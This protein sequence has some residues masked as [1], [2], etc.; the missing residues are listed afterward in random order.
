MKPRLKILFVEDEFPYA[1]LL[2]NRFAHETDPS[3]E[4]THVSSLQAAVEHSAGKN[5]DVVL[6]DLCLPD[7]G[8]LDTL[9]ALHTHAPATPIVVL[10]ALGDGSLGIEAVKK[11]AQDYL[12]KG[13]FEGKDLP[14]FLKYAIARHEKQTELCNLS[15]VD[16]LTGLKNRRGLSVLAEQQLKLAHRSGAELLF[17]YIDLDGLKHVN[18]TYGHSEGDRALQAVAQ[19]LN[20]TFRETDVV[21]RVGG[22][23]FTVL[24]ID[25]ATAHTQ[26]LLTRLEKVLKEHNRKMAFPYDLSLSVGVSSFNLNQPCSLDELMDRADRAMY[27]QKRR[28]KALRQ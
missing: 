25:A 10:T 24:A 7:S 9:T 14:R 20:K 15:L 23:E 6:L 4:V 17:F 5:A 3:F 13:R 22:D 1:E 27:E 16:E 12:V 8:G 28:R 21:A 19:I 11:G 18:D 26:T 2:Q